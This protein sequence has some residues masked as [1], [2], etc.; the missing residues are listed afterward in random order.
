MIT[1]RIVSAT[2][3]TEFDLEDT[4]LARTGNQVDLE[5]LTEAQVKELAVWSADVSAAEA[6]PLQAKKL[7]SGNW[8]VQEV[9]SFGKAGLCICGHRDAFH[10]TSG[11]TVRNC[12]CN[13]YRE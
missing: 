1:V 4:W 7:Q 9:A 8:M 13:R 12:T 3:D 11:C 6:R 5:R 10:V 2:R